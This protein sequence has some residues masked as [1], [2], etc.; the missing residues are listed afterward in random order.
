MNYTRGMALL[1]ENDVEHYISPR[2]QSC[3]PGDAMQFTDASGAY[4]AANGTMCLKFIDSDKEKEINVGVS[5]PYD[6]MKKGECII[7][8]DFALKGVNVG[9]I[10]TIKVQWEGYWNNMRA[11]YNKAALVEGW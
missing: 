6:K 1:E 2:Y 11:E 7:A 8:D 4:L 3:P 9:D 10:V 5:W